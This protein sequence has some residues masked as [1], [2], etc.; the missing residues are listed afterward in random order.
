M[1]VYVEVSD[2]MRNHMFY[3]QFI[4]QTSDNDKLFYLFMLLIR[5]NHLLV[6]SRFQFVVFLFAKNTIGCGGYFWWLCITS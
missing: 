6:I 1:F 4:W 2:G 3:L 5:F